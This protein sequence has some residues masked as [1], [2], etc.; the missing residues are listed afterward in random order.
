MIRREI[1]QRAICV[2]LAVAVTSCATVADLALRSRYLIWTDQILRQLIPFFPFPQ[3]YAGVGQLSLSNLVFLMAPDL[4]KVRIGLRANVS[5]SS[6]LGEMTGIPALG[7]V[8]GKSTSG[9]CQVA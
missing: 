3:Q 4:D 8:A 7:R 6:V 5:A 9:T 2:P 1:I